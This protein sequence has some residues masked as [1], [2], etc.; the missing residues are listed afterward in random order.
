MNRWLLLVSLAVVASF[1]VVPGNGAPVL[2]QTLDTASCP[3]A[4]PHE[5]VV[6]YDVYGSTLAGPFDLQLVV[7]ADGMARLST[8]NA[9]NGEGKSQVAAVGAS[10]AK[11]LLLALTAGGAFELCDDTSFA[12]DL[13]LS[14]LTVMRA[15]T[16]V[17]AH[18]YSWWAGQGP[19]GPPEQTLVGFVATHFPNF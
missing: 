13:P 11:N 7:Y 4:L 14:T 8:T 10:A 1:L 9:H 5:P 3:N 12:L 19:Y 2:P 18:T 17:R 6:L 16:N 15:G